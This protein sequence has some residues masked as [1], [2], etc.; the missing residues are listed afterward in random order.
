[1]SRHVVTMLPGTTR[2]DDSRDA[3]LGILMIEFTD[4]FRL[5]VTVRTSG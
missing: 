4:V 3:D 2:R 5:D 1:M